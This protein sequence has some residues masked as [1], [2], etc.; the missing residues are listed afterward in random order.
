MI[1]Q[2]NLTILLILCTS[3]VLRGDGCNVLE[4]K[5]VEQVAGIP[6]PAEWVSIGWTDASGS[7]TDSFDASIAEDLRTAIA[8]NGGADNLVAINVSGVQYKVLE[9][10]GHDAQREGSVTVEPTGTGSP[11]GLL[12]FNIP[13]NETGRSGAAGD[14]SGELIMQISGTTLVNGRINSWLD[15]YKANPGDTSYDNLLDLTFE[16]NWTSTPAPSAQSPDNFTWT[17]DLV[18]QVVQIITI[19]GD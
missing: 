7:Y 15:Q 1:T 14:G 2:R 18:L 6:V 13:G 9:S 19:N 11:L 10:T 4:Q 12:V 5:D 3:L 17:T 8:E 16:V